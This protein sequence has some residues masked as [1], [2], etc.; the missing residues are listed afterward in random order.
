[1]HKSDSEN[2]TFAELFC[3]D[4]AA[5]HKKYGEV[6]GGD[7][8]ATVGGG[9][10]PA[11]I[12]SDDGF[13][14]SPS[15]CANGVDERKLRE[16]RKHSPRDTI[17]LHGMTAAEAHAELDVFLQDAMRRNIT[18]VEVIHGKGASVQDAV[19]R[20][21]TRK[22]LA[23]CAAVLAYCEAGGNSGALRV[24]LRKTRR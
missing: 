24:L 1:M 15:Y 22:W 5:P 16:L 20:P 6:K 3:E 12:G 2:E 14:D 19:L 9:I 21:K 11:D 23:G 10:L 7:A 18:R 4:F 13:R 17:D 8:S